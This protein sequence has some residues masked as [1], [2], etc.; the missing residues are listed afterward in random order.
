MKTRVVKAVAMFVLLV[1]AQL[2]VILATDHRIDE[3][4]VAASVIVAGV[5]TIASVASGDI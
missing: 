2:L 5:I 3:A 1:V 4:I